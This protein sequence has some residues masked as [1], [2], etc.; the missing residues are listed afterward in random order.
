VFPIHLPP[1]RERGEDILPLAEYFLQRMSERMGRL[2]T[3]I[4]PASL[5]RLQ[6]F[7][8]P[9]NIRQLQNVI[10]H[11]A[12]LS[13]DPLLIIPATLLAEKKAGLVCA[14]KLDAALHDGE[15]QMIEQALAAAHGRVSGLAGAARRLGV[16]ASTLESKIKRF[17][18]DKQRFR[19][20]N[21]A[22]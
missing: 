3:G 17:Q 4:E 6:A 12:I 22:A 21:D 5:D 19:T 14:S 2:F 7:S 9:G 1:L 11:C 18:I 13:D 16:P 8:W 15:Q 10:E 20:M